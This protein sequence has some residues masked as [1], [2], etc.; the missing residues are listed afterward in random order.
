MEKELLMPGLLY[1]RMNR[2]EVMTPTDVFNAIES[3]TYAP[4]PI[5]EELLI[6]LDFD[7]VP[8]SSNATI[9]YRE[10]MHLEPT[11]DTKKVWVCCDY[12]DILYFQWVHE[13]Q[14]FWLGYHKKLLS[15]RQISVEL[16]TTVT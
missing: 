14:L 12:Q 16:Y 9:F 6:L 7:R 13:V 8:N 2:L 15:L 4:M 3:D 11:D 10:G 5:T 1:T